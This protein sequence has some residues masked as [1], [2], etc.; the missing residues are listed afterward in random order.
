MLKNVKAIFSLFRS[1]IFRAVDIARNL[2]G[3]SGVK[4]WDCQVSTET[5]GII[6]GVG[7]CT[8]IVVSKKNENNNKKILGQLVDVE[9]CTNFEGPTHCNEATST[10]R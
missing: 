6:S 2:C 1:F 10:K 4:A 3:I 5:V 9:E 8:G 7:V